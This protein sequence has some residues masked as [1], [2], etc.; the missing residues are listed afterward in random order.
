MP[1]R[2]SARP[3]AAEPSSIIIIASEAI[4]DFEAAA[5]GPRRRQAYPDR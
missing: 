2:L 5:F 3:G 1:L 4:T